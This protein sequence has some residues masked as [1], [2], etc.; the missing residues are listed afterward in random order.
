MHKLPSLDLLIKPMLGASSLL[1]S[2][3]VGYRRNQSKYYL[4]LDCIGAEVELIIICMARSVLSS[5]GT[6][7]VELSIYSHTQ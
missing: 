4:C 3:S 5:L 1:G 2:H 6:C 7:G